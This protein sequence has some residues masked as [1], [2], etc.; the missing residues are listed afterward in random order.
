MLCVLLS[1]SN[2]VVQRVGGE[3]E[4]TRW[5]TVS[6]QLVLPSRA[7]KLRLDTG[8]WTLSSATRGCFCFEPTPGALGEKATHRGGPLGTR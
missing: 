8:A 1:V 4:L 7:P 2:R 3:P 5:S 6:P